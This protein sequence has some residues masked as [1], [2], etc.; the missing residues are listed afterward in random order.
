MKIHRAQ[1]TIRSTVVGFFFRIFNLLMPFIVRT[2]LIKKLGSEFLGLNSLYTSIIQVLNLAELGIGSALVFNMYE[3]IANDDNE[4]IGYLL[5]LYKKIYSIIGVL[6]FVIGLLLIPTLS[7]LVDMRELE[8][9]G[10]NAYVLYLIYLMNSV[11]SY[12]FFAYRKSLLMAYQR[13]DIVSITN[14]VAHI[15]MYSLQMIVLFTCPN[16]YLYIILM[17]IFTVIDN[18]SAVIISKRMFPDI[19]ETKKVSINDMG[20]VFSRVKYLIGHKVGAVILNSADSIV[21]SAFI[22]LKILT[23]YG[24]YFYIISALS[25]F[26]HVGYT[27]LLAGVGN[28]IVMESKE[29]LLR[30]FNDLTFLIF[31]VV[32]IGTICLLC[33]YQPFMEL[34]MG[35]EY[36][37]PMQTVVLFS[38]YFYTWQVRVMGLI[39][40]DAGGMWKNDFYKPYIGMVVNISLNLF[41]VNIWGVNGVIVATIVVM[42]LVY[43]PCETHV[44]FKDLFSV[45]PWRYILRHVYYIMITLIGCIICFFIT[46][47]LPVEGFIGLVV[48]GMLAV[49][50]ANATVILLCLRMPE[51]KNMISRVRRVFSEG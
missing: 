30:L 26:I 14:G 1:N 29:R 50:G 31:Y 46:S 23:A 12:L 16:Y 48:K 51:L 44:L 6:I 24:N 33:L 20:E 45:K 39:F 32:S 40:K 28:S 11:L 13:Q 18:I 8:G 38:I 2:V 36:M 25:G 43:F 7:Y 34:W 47:V 21:I 10:I 41:L 27:A 17:P 4:K 37:F 42:T 15:I 19:K 9:T 49:I 3:P 35:E 5:G 22:N